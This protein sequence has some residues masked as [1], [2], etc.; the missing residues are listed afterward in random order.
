MSGT[1]TGSRLTA[2]YNRIVALK[3]KL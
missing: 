2:S 1:L 3:S